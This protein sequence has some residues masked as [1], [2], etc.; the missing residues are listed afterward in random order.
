[1]DI[2]SETVWPSEGLEQGE[3]LNLALSAAGVMSC[4]VP[5]STVCLWFEEIES[6]VLF[7][8]APTS[9]CPSV[10]SDGSF[11]FPATQITL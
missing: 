4:L 6:Q 5:L 8:A 3:G 2:R 9:L 10:C 11:N 1:M 7:T